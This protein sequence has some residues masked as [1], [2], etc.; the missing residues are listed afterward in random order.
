MRMAL[1]SL[2]LLT[3]ASVAPAALYCEV[4]ENASP[5]AGLESYTVWFKGTVASDALAAFD[6]RID[7]PL[8]QVWG[9]VGDP[10][11]YMSTVHNPSTSDT[12]WPGT[13][14]IDQ[15]SRML[16]AS[17]HLTT[18]LTA[19]DEDAS[20][21]APVVGWMMHQTGTGTY[22]ASTATTNMIF[23]IA[24]GA[25]SINLAFAQLV[26]AT[27]DEVR[28]TGEAAAADEVQKLE[29]DMVIPEPATLGLLLLGA[30]AALI[31]RRRR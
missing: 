16:L 25:R 20:G 24:T 7:G 6:G 13:A 10:I 3:V 11:T 23:G 18:V 21:M 29:L 22:L 1:I 26:L 5:G 30:G 8:N 9:A 17:G 31:R 14:H 28:L 2:V 19:P 15:D 4:T 12:F 27:G